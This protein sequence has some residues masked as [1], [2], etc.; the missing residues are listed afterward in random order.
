MH[1]EHMPLY[2]A[3]DK[4]NMTEKTARKYIKT[5]KGPKALKKPHTWKTHKDAFEGVWDEVKGFLEG[6]PTLQA[7]TLMGWLHEQN[8][9][10]F[11]DGQLRTLQRRVKHWRLHYGEGK[12]V[13]FAQRHHPG[14]RLQSDFTHMDDL[15]VT[16]QGELFRHM[17]FHAVLT[18]SNWETGRI[19]S[20]ES[21]EALSIGLQDA[22]WDLGGVPKTH[23]T[24][25]LTAAV[26][27]SAGA[28]E[29]TARYEAILRHYNLEGSYSQVAK[30][31]E[32]G[33]VEQRHYRFKGSVDQALMLRGSRDFESHQAYND[34]LRKLLNQLN[35]GRQKRLSEEMRVLSPLPAC[36]LD[37]VSKR[38]VLVSQGS[39]I[40]VGGNIYSVHSRLI[41]SHVEAHIHADHIEVRVN[42]RCVESH[43][44]LHGKGKARID[45]RHIIH[46]L[47]RKPGAFKNYIYREQLF[48]S[49]QFRM[50]Y[51]TLCQTQ[52][53]RQAI[54]DYLELLKL[55]ASISQDRVEAAISDCLISPESFTQKAVVMVMDTHNTTPKAI[56][57]VAIDPVSLAD[58]DVLISGKVVSV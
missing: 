33:D 5:R 23:Q 46:T 40:T 50:A 3:A 38:R 7:K 35:Q 48:P 41:G 17:F 51:D 39:T 29:F 49:T 10:Q 45:Y 42:G 12:E 16:I 6:N 27:Q 57:D 52:S 18:Y 20:S 9:G 11:E 55:A 30:P 15:Q 14:E 43:P 24:D 58:Y 1:K 13:F 34:F 26:K 47:L 2:K 53:E 8:P 31:N 19:C 56:P 25:Q 36:R 54:K 4:A 28:K 32:N 22:L 37:T 21:F 44:R